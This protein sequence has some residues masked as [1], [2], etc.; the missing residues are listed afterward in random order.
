MVTQ[1]NMRFH[2]KTGAAP[3]FRNQMSKRNG[4]NDGVW[5]RNGKGGIGGEAAFLFGCLKVAAPI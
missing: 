5:E 1:N 2:G 3:P 4:G